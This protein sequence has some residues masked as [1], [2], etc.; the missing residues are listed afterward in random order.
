MTQIAMF[1]NEFALFQA[2]VVLLLP[3]VTASLQLP[4]EDRHHRRLP[5]S[6]T[7]TPW[8]VT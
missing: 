5:C 8:A 1:D 4:L 2:L 6:T 3:L 7:S